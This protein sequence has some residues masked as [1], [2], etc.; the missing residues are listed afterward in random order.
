MVSGIVHSSSC[1]DF[2]HSIFICNELAAYLA[3]EACIVT[4]VEPFSVG[5]RK[6]IEISIHKV[7]RFKAC[8]TALQ[9]QLLTQGKSGP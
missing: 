1:R 2:H 8:G 3:A 6:V 4:T 5:F 7:V 9:K